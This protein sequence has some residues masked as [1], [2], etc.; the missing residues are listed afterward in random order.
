M[1]R[2]YTNPLPRTKTIKP[3]RRRGHR[4]GEVPELTTEAQRAQSP[5]PHQK[6]INHEGHEEHEAPLPQHPG[7]KDFN[8]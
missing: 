4:G 7:R 5:A 3:Q 8:L 1:K 6:S 2:K